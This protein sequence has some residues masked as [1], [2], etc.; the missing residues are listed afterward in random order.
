MNRCIMAVMA[1]A[2]DLEVYA[3]GTMAKFTDA[4]YEGVLVMLTANMGGARVGGKGYRRTLPQEAI[5][6]RAAE[7]RA[8][9]EILGVSVIE[10]MKFM[11]EVYSDG[12]KF[13]YLGDPGYDVNHP[14]AGM[15]LVAAALHPEAVDRLKG[16]LA[17]YEPEIVISHSFTSGFGHTAAAH[18]TNQAFGLALKE[19]ASLGQL[20]VSSRVRHCAWESDVRLYPPPNILIDISDV[21]ERKE[22]ALLAHES[23]GLAS[24]IEKLKA[25]DR[26][27]GIAHQCELAEP[28]TMIRDGRY[29]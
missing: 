20:W 6:L 10:E 18:L 24:Q 14:A 5:P 21:W 17:R 16:L 15:P 29:S 28:F 25:I 1:H 4:G 26:H 11:G 3:G 8:G 13:V 12:E 27:W 23:Q 9:A 2:D 22:R 7:V 19:G